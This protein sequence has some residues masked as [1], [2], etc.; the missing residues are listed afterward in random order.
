MNSNDLLTLLSEGFKKQ[1]EKL[2]KEHKDV[3]NNSDVLMQN[4]MISNYLV[5]KLNQ[6][7]K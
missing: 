4:E 1:N 5:Q 3:L 2:K 6:T 7:K